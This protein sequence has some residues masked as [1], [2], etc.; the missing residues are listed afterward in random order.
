MLLLVAQRQKRAT[1]A[2]EEHPLGHRASGVLLGAGRRARKCS[3]AAPY[4]RSVKASRIWFI[5][6]EPVLVSELPILILFHLVLPGRAVRDSGP[7]ATLKRE[8]RALERTFLEHLDLSSDPVLRAVLAEDAAAIVGN[9]IAGVGIALH[10]LTG[11][12]VPDGVAAIMIGLLLGFVAL[13]LAARNGD[14]L[15]GAQASAALRGGVEAT[16][17]AQPGVLGVSELLVTFI[18]PRQVW[19]VA[20]VAIDAGLNGASVEAL[21]RNAEAALRRESPFI[22][23]VD[24]VPRG[25]R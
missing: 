21:V 17:V 8:A 22:A 14:V 24:L 4:S 6:N 5:A 13:Q 20:R 16:L 2:D 10:Q 19:V 3:G 12:A 25:R 23:R 11:S 1:A 7:A 18:G 15:I 9:L